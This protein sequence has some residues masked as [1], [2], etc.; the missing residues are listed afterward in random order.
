[1]KHSY[2]KRSFSIPSYADTYVPKEDSS[3]AF[4]RGWIEADLDFC[5]NIPF[6]G[7]GGLDQ[8]S[9]PLVPSY[10]PLEQEEEWL[11]GYFGQVYY[12]LGSDWKTVSFSWSPAIDLK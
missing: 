3:G 8:R 7:I 4:L 2:R 9:D 12:R 5:E 1:M 6:C 10:I 11:L